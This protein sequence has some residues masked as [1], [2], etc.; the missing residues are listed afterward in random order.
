MT[1]REDGGLKA[2]AGF[3]S[4]VSVGHDG[5]DRLVELCLTGSVIGFDG[6]CVCVSA[7]L[8]IEGN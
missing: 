2:S 7:A 1:A 4:C 8:H 6:A 3:F 5:C